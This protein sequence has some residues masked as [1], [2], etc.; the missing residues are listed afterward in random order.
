M[1]DP[2]CFKESGGDCFFPA[3]RAMVLSLV[4]H[5]IVLWG[6]EFPRPLQPEGRAKL[7]AVIGEPKDSARPAANSAQPLHAHE[8]AWVQP[9]HMPERRSG[10]RSH[11]QSGQSGLDQDLQPL[12]PGEDLS[13]YRLALGR[14]FGSLLDEELRRVLP[15]GELLFRIHYRA[16]PV[17]PSMRLTAGVAPAISARLLDAMARA[18]AM[19][20][21]P[22]SWQSGSYRLELRAQVVGA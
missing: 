16:G 17:P 7:S 15:P 14:A 12:P 1:N 21:L 6:T 13:A 4:L 19:T 2:R 20:P 3:G 11:T 5:A 8:E 10:A 18:V 22:S 9:T